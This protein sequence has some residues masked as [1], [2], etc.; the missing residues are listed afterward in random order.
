MNSGG[1][2]NLARGEIREK[3]LRFRYIYRYGY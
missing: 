3:G 2:M 1:G